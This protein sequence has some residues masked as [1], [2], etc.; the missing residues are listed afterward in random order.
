MICLWQTL[1]MKMTDGIF[2]GEM[3]GV[4]AR[5]LGWQPKWDQEMYLNSMDEEVRGV[6]E[7]D[8]MK[9]TVLQSL[10]VSEQAA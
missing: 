5:Q 6:L 7:L 10:L 2:S 1:K 4:N 8:D 9:P 3:V